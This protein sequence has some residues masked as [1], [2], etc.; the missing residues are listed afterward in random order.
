MGMNIQKQSTGR[1]GKVSS[2][3][4]KK[5]GKAISDRGIV[6][7]KASYNNTIVMV[8]NPKGQKITQE[9]GGSAGFKNSRKSTSEAAEVAAKRA[10]EY[11][12]SRGMSVVDVKLNGTGTGREGAV[13]GLWLAGLTV[14]TLQDVT[15]IAHNGV[16]KKKR[17]RK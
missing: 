10:A 13:R 12:K 16:K 5:G 15:G 4:R 1:K 14:A 9:S 3:S 6:F 11:V 17:Q 2:S 7:I 8:A